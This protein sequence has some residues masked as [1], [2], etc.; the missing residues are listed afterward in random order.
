M[1]TIL[2]VGTSVPEFVATNDYVVFLV[3]EHSRRIYNGSLEELESKLR[4]FLERAG[5]ERRCWRTKRTKPLMHIEEAWQ[6]CFEKARIDPRKD[7]GALIYCGIDK[8]VIEPSHASL[9]AK[10]FGILHARTLDI[11]DACMGWFTA[12][13]I[14]RAMSRQSGRYTAIIS[15]EFPIEVP[16]KVYPEALKIRDDTDL[17]WKAAA[18]TLGE[19]ASVTL[20]DG[21][22][23]ESVIFRSN[24]NHADLC[25]VPI[26]CP[27]RFI[28]F[29]PLIERLAE[30]CFVAHTSKMIAASYKDAQTVLKD[31]ISMYG[32]PDTILPHTVS[33]NGPAFASRNIVPEDALK[34]CFKIFGNISTSAIPV[35]YEYFRCNQDNRKH[36]AG[37]ISAAGMSHSV[38]RLYS[39]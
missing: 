2:A 35:G 22:E 4:L 32:I 14:A 6:N 36:V 37:W 28:D 7:L 3:I 26:A 17:S 18:L 33:Y 31:Y 27:E 1:P 29:H 19:C 38:F 24:N 12:A 25:C 34:N 16:G 8:G 20:V 11:S 10:R 13:Q 23:E 39:R 9:L 15:A 5:S 21:S 30:D